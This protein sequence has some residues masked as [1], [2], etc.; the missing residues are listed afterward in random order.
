M[1]V[2]P[3]AVLSDSIQSWSSLI[4]YITQGLQL[5]PQ[6]IQ[7]QLSRRRPGQ[8]DLT[9]PVSAFYPESFRIIRLN[10]DRIPERRER[11]CSYS[12]RP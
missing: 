3:Y 6:D 8:S 4:L 1:V 12:I 7:I 2:H 10:I 9:T 11:P 5:T